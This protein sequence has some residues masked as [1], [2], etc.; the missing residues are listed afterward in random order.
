MN[1]TN[2]DG[3]HGASDTG[4]VGGVLQL[5]V[6]VEVD[7]FDAAVAFY[8]DHLGMPEEFSVDSGDDARVVALRA[9]RAT[10][11]L[12]TSEQRRLIDRLEVGRDVSPPI[13][14][15]FEVDDVD[16]ATTRAID[17]GA[18]PVAA[19]TATPWRSRNARLDGPG[20]IHLTLFEELEPG[21]PS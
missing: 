19:P 1:D 20:P 2:R 11:E 18:E 17:A 6:V 5:R 10:L 7:D 15:A 16:A 14:I 8:R 4:G 3:R 13:R 21:A 12:V 9:G